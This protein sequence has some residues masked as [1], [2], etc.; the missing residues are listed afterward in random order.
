M[1]KIPKIPKNSDLI[2]NINNNACNVCQTGSAYNVCKD[3]LTD[4][5]TDEKCEKSCSSTYNASSYYYDKDGTKR[6]YCGKTK[7]SCEIAGRTTYVCDGKKNDMCLLNP[8]SSINNITVSKDVNNNSMCKEECKKILKTDGLYCKENNK[9]I[10]INPTIIPYPITPTPPSTCT[11]P[12]PNTL[13]CTD[14]ITPIQPTSTPLLPETY[15]KYG[16]FLGK[17]TSGDTEIVRTAFCECDNNIALAYNKN[18]PGCNPTLGKMWSDSVT[19]TKNKTNPDNN[20]LYT[21]FNNAINQATGGDI[22]KIKILAAYE[23]CRITNDKY[24]RTK[25]TVSPNPA[26]Q[27][28]EWLKYHLGDTAKSGILL[29]QS[30]KILV[31]VMLVHILFRTVFPPAAHGNFTITL[32]YAM[33]LPQEFLRNSPIMKVL[34]L[35]SSIILML[36]I[37]ALLQFTTIQTTNYAILTIGC[38]ILLFALFCFVSAKWLF[39][40]SLSLLLILPILFL[41]TYLINKKLSDKKDSDKDRQSNGFV[42]YFI[43]DSI[44]GIYKSGFAFSIYAVII[45]AIITKMAFPPVIMA[46]VIFLFILF[47]L[48]VMGIITAIQ[49]K[50]KVPDEDQ[51][52][53]NE[54]SKLYL[55]ILVCFF[56]FYTIAYLIDLF[57]GGN[58]SPSR[59]YIPFLLS[60]LFGVLP[61][62]TFAIIINFAIAS[63]SPAIELLFLVMY[64]MSGFL[65]IRYPT[66][67]VGQTLL[68][69]SGKRINDKWVLPFLPW[70]THIIN[71]Y[72]AVAGTAKPLYYATTN[73]NTGVT[74]TEMWFS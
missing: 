25:E 64:R 71:A 29:N 15:M 58:T 63:Y 12:G 65:A 32:I 17:G 49:A 70:V 13:L 54:Y 19:Q 68:A 47:S 55:I 30:V 14:G 48:I 41:L 46:V 36:V 56:A 27:P 8:N 61:L 60:T 39:K 72:Y 6:C 59:F 28:G 73:L 37:M 23:M 2:Q 62:A 67:F 38:I 16:D 22:D 20:L 50:K 34:V 5:K 74:N 9:C 7:I 18:F 57:G 26:T 43:P 45:G 33:F 53:R 4:T 1:S 3:P 51:I 11:P 66:N 44:S 69:I 40:T 35:V 21:Y 52:F 31:M 24:K 42:E 10:C